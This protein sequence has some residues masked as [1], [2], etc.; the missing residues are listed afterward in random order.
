MSFT[1]IPGQVKNIVLDFKA[2]SEF[3]YASRYEGQDLIKI[4]L[5]DGYSGVVYFPVSVASGDQ[6]VDFTFEGNILE[7]DDVKVVFLPKIS[8]SRVTPETPIGFSIEAKDLLENQIVTVDLFIQDTK[9]YSKDHTFEKNHQYQVF[10]QEVPTSYD[11]G[12]YDVELVVRHEDSSTSAREW[13]ARQQVVVDEY[14]NLDI[15]S[16]FSKNLIK[17]E[18]RIVITNLGNIED[19]FTY[20]ISHNGFM[21]L[22]FGAELSDGKDL[23]YTTKNG[24]VELSIPLQKG[25]QVEFVYYY[26]FIPLYVILFVIA[27][28]VMYIYLRKTSNPLSV[29]T[30]IYEVKKDSHEG[31][32]SIKLRIGFENIRSEEIES[33]R[34]IFRM[35][36][37]L[38]VKDDSF[39]LTP[40]KQ[41]LK[42]NSHYKLV[43]DFKRFEKEDSRILGFKLVNSKGILGDVRIEDLE[44]EVKI[45][46]R[47]RKYYSSFP[48]VRG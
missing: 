46:G 3:E 26:N 22:F 15:S 37:Y 8:S 23:D 13:N 4:K 38:S 21:S 30:R 27:V 35:P 10:Q 7:K 33:L 20:T 34:M 47:V 41:V 9:I 16:D 43:W 24:E 28:L 1:L 11:P 36:N 29:E 31:V 32:K 40:P 2:N 44:F 5:N 39:L 42:G 25:E 17:D 45:N 48:I 12:R 19:T 18:A 6:K 14:K